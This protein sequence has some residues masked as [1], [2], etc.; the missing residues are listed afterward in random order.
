MSVV[1]VAL[2]QING[3]LDN[4]IKKKTWNELDIE[5]EDLEITQKGLQKEKKRVKNNN[6]KNISEL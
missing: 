5:V 6:G 1:K 4:E 3:R 2:D